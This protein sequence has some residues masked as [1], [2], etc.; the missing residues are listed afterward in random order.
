ML[1]FSAINDFPPSM[2][3]F[4]IIYIDPKKPEKLHLKVSSVYVAC[5]IYLL[6]LLI[7]V[8]TQPYIYRMHKFIVRNCIVL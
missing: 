6:T 7:N 8:S 5:C 3:L 1:F 2:F 4:M